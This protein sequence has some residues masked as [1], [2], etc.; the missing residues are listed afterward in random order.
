MVPE[1]IRA[2]GQFVADIAR[3]LRSGLNSASSDVAALLADGWRGDA[4]NEFFGGWTE[5]R[6]G[7]VKILQAL[8]VMTE[9]LGVQ[10]NSYQAT[11]DSTS[12]QFPSL[13]LHL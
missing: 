5:L 6:D 2:V 4:S 11:D 1:E 8:D 13:N 10:A 3:Q 9:R 12:Q 7:G